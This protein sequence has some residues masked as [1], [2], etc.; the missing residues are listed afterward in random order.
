MKQIALFIFIGLLFCS[1]ALALEVSGLVERKFDGPVLFSLRLSEGNARYK[2]KGSTK[3][4]TSW[5][6]WND[7]IPVRIFEHDFSTVNVIKEITTPNWTVESRK[8]KNEGVLDIY[9][10]E[11]LL[12]GMTLADNPVSGKFKR[13]LF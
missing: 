13:N 2:I 4:S 3:F 8:L 5:R 10:T 11:R 9:L 7:L 12:S 6:W 1:S